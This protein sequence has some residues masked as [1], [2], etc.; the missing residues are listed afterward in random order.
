[1]RKSRLRVLLLFAEA[2]DCEKNLGEGWARSEER[3]AAGSL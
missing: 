3:M 2:G 1:M